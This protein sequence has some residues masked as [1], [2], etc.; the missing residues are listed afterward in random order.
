VFP[1]RLF[2]AI[3]S[4]FAEWGWPIRYRLHAHEV[5]RFQLDRGVSRVVAL[6]Y[7]HKPG[8]ARGLNRFV[9]E[10][11]AEE[12]RVI[13]VGTVQPGEAGAREILLEAFD[14][15]LAGVKLHCHVQCFAPDDE[16]LEVIYET[17]A[18][19]D[20]PLVMHAGREPKSPGYRCDPHALCSADRVERVLARHPRLRLCVPHLGAD[21]YV[22]YA[23]L[24]ERYDNLWVDT[25]M[26]LADYFPGHVPTELFWV[27][28]E[29]VMYGTDFPSIPFAW[30]R[31]LTR[32]ARAG[33]GEEAL[34]S[35]LGG[36]ARALF[37]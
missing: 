16:A 14:A 24:L 19:R 34:A 17:C 15:G 13:G 8:I 28:P 37:G 35:V 3:W 22:A 29:R 21:E 2:E 1:D 12:P 25:T 11:V 4:W 33:L 32:L 23:R 30:D 27:R 26:T 18:E 9:A 31:E 36:T 10:L 5:I 20:R 7:A 6:T